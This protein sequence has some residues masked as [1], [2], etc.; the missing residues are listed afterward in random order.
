MTS[1]VAVGQ[2]QG[3]P[4]GVTI[5]A[6]TGSVVGVLATALA[7]YLIVDALSSDRGSWAYIVPLWLLILAV[8]L[9]L[10]SKSAIAGRGS[11]LLIVGSALTLLPL[12]PPA[13]VM[14]LYPFLLVSPV[15]A[16][17][18]AA[19][20]AAMMILTIALLCRSS[21]GRYFAAHH[22]AGWLSS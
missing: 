19:T 16:A 1:D 12:P 6:S 22:S 9:I 14:L 15:A 20:L 10:G 5:A 17:F 3:R 8:L 11:T 18:I 2:V 21:A 13:P 4:R 7:T